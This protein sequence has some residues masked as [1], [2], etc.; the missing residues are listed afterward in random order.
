MFSIDVLFISKKLH[1][2]FCACVQN[3]LKT[4]TVV[5]GKIKL[6]SFSLFLDYSPLDPRRPLD[7]N[8]SQHVL[9]Y[10]IYVKGVLGLVGGGVVQAK[11]LTKIDH[12]ARWSLFC[13]SIV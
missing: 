3:I 9:T 11:H 4:V 12:F 8:M 5:I 7:N 2:S 10:T 13:T 1:Y 6:V